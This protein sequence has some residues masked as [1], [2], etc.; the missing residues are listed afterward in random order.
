MEA[1]SPIL[2]YLFPFIFFI[3][4]IGCNSYDVLKSQPYEKDEVVEEVS[5]CEELK[6]YTYNGFYIPVEDGKLFKKHNDS[7][8]VNEV[9]LI[10]FSD[11]EQVQKTFDALSK[12]SISIVLNDK[13]TLI[14]KEHTAN[15]I[16]NKIAIII[17]DSLV[18]AP[19]INS[20]ITAGLLEISSSF[21]QQEVNDLSNYLIQ[22]KNCK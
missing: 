17:K 10:L 3:Q 18:V 22:L 12:P 6:K 14:F 8:R 5:N 4:Y 20:E 7:I 15:N 16:G 19:I 11:L 21:T 9:P 1:E 2:K 13:A